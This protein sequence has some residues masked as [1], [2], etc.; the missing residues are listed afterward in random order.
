[1]KTQII[2]HNQRDAVYYIAPIVINECKRFAGRL[3]YS[4]YGVR[5]MVKI[6][7]DMTTIGYM[8]DKIRYK[9]QI[10]VMVDD[11]CQ[12]PII[13]V[14]APFI[15]YDIFFKITF[16]NMNEKSGFKLEYCSDRY[17]VNV[18]DKK[19][20]GLPVSPL[21]TRFIKLN[22]LLENIVRTESENDFVVDASKPFEEIQ[23]DQM[24]E[25][26]DEEDN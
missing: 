19:N 22:E 2:I 13:V 16:D 6:D 5:P 18:I 11:S 14:G 3:V 17:G 10:T 23:E 7:F 20:I 8:I 24:I 12:R 1:M 9:P 26:A 21:S 4:T 15:K 25:S